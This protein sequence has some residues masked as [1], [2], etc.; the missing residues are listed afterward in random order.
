MLGT[1]LRKSEK[2]Y[3]CPRC[4]AAVEDITDTV[5]GRVYLDEVR[6]EL[7]IEQ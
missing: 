7:G 6:P 5:L 3:V 4:G 2:G 1:M